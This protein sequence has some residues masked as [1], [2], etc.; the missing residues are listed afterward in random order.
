MFRGVCPTEKLEQP[1]LWE[2]GSLLIPAHEPAL[3]VA[4]STHAYGLKGH[5]DKG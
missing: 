2:M 5:F 3:E 4:H 1:S